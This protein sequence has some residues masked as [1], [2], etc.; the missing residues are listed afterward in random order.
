MGS[1]FLIKRII[2]QKTL[3]Y[4]KPFFFFFG[5]FVAFSEELTWSTKAEKLGATSSVEISF[6]DDSCL[7]QAHHPISDMVFLTKE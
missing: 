7:K 2:Y 6:F 5:L 3:A 4:P 1:E